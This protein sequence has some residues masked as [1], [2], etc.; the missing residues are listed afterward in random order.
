MG[1]I[2]QT[3][4][5]ALPVVDHVTS[6]QMACCQCCHQGQLP[7]HHRAAHDSGQ[8]PRVFPGVVSAR[9]LDA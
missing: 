5:S 6:D 1:K 8:L 2:Y 9:S 4:L 7:R 3:S